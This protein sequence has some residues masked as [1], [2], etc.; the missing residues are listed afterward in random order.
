MRRSIRKRSA[1]L[2]DNALRHAHD[3][4]RVVVLTG[5]QHVTVEVTDDG[6]GI[7]PADRER[8]FERFTRLDGA[9]SRVDGGA[10]LGLAIARAIAATHGGTLT[11]EEPTRTGCGARLVVRRRPR[12][13]RAPLAPR[14]EAHCR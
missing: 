11:A 6:P 9:R 3:R 7:A 13:T 1:N 10:G 14:P 8:I 12:Y 2:V 4:V 5:P